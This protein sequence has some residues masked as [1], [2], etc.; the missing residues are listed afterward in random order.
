[1]K[2]ASAWA[3]RSYI[4]DTRG[5]VGLM[6]PAT[7]FRMAREDAERAIELDSNVPFRR[8]CLTMNIDILSIVKHIRRRV[9]HMLVITRFFSFLVVRAANENLRGNSSWT[10]KPPSGALKARTLPPCARAMRSVIASQRPVPSGFVLSGEET[11]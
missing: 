3:L 1:M 10:S 7:A 11:R 5:D 9:P 4:L 8:M 6:E 2:Y